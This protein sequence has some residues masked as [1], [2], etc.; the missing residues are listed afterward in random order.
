MPGDRWVADAAFCTALVFHY[1][2]GTG[3]VVV[4]VLK[5]DGGSGLLVVDLDVSEEFVILVL[6]IS[7]LR[8]KQGDVAAVVNGE[9]E[10]VAVEVV[11]LGDGP[12]GN[13]L[14]PVCD[15]DVQPEGLICRK[16]F[17]I[18]ETQVVTEVAQ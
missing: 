11:A 6:A 2:G 5:R 9:F 7:H 18:A 13:D 3:V 10:F 1:Q 16:Q 12:V 15:L 14:V 4:A 8:R 17:I